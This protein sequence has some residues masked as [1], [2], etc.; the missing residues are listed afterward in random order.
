M[1]S[2]STYVNIFQRDTDVGI[3]P[4]KLFT[5]ESYLKLLT[6]LRRIGNSH[7]LDVRTVEKALFKKNIDET[8]S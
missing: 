2:K 6:E 3:Q 5:T 8:S 7:G 1:N 4:A